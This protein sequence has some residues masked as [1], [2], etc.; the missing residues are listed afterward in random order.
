MRGG[1]VFVISS[2][3]FLVIFFSSLVSACIP[4]SAGCYT[5]NN[6]VCESSLG[7][8]CSN[9][10]ADC[11]QCA[12][13]GDGQCNGNENVYSCAQDCGRCGD[14]VVSSVLGEQCDPPGVQAQ[15]NA[16]YKCASNCKSCVCAPTCGDGTCNCGETAKFLSILES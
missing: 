6:H 16:G 5:C 9:C 14:N 7:E 15:C 13:C 8:T 2:L 10:A 1:R 3:L 11:G 12:T 4:G